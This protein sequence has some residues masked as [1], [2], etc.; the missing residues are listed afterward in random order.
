MNTSHNITAATHL[1]IYLFNVI[2]LSIPKSPNWYHPL[3]L[4]D[5]NLHTFLSSLMHA[6]WHA[7]FIILDLSTPK[8]IWHITQIMSFS[9]C[10]TIH[11]PATSSLKGPDILCCT[12]FSKMYNL[13]SSLRVK[14]QVSYPYETTKQQLI[15]YICTAYPQVVVEKWVQAME[16]RHEYVQNKQ[17]WPPINGQSSIFGAGQATKKPSNVKLTCYADFRLSKPDTLL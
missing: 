12:L 8:N 15:L 16:G 9:L 7:H 13:H 5:Y 3:R 2:L 14:N 4:S 6:K 1:F 17:S 11:N 10:S